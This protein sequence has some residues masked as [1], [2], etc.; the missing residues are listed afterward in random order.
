MTCIASTSWCS[1]CY[2]PS[3]HRSSSVSTMSES[4]DVGQRSIDSTRSAHCSTGFNAP[5]PLTRS[6]SSCTYPAAVACDCVSNAGERASA[7]CGHVK[8][9]LRGW[10][11]VVVSNGAE[12]L[13]R[14]AGFHTQ[15]DFRLGQVRSRRKRRTSGIMGMRSAGC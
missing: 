6:Q 7:V 5:R 10:F 4:W 11:S 15:G 3:H 13:V 2:N 14:V 1:T 8:I 9:E 12:D